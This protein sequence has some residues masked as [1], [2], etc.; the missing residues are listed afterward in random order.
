MH[1]T[2][3]D[4]ATVRRMRQLDA[5][6]N[7]SAGTTVERADPDAEAAGRRHSGRS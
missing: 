7:D 3:L 5:D 6:T 1:L 4:Q 2:G